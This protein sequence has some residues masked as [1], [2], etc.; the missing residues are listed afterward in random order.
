VAPGAGRPSR[1]IRPGNA[2]D[3]ALQVEE[4]AGR[5]GQPEA[6]DR[7]GEGRPLGQLLLEAA[8]AHRHRLLPQEPDRK[9]DGKRGDEQE[10]ER[11]G[12]GPAHRERR[13]PRPA[14]AS[15]RLR[16]WCALS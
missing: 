15:S 6:P 7:L 9:P 14:G 3:R 13:L 4:I 16:R 8:H 2:Q 12:D 1:R 10:S 11:D 5:R